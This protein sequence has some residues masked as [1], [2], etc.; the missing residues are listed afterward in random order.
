MRTDL[1]MLLAIVTILITINAFIFS[2]NEEFSSGSTTT[3]L[4]GEPT[5]GNVTTFWLGI[6]VW[7]FGAVPVWVDTL[8]LMTRAFGYIIFWKVFI[9]GVGT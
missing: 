3:N 6:F 7:T 2:I 4:V 9:R 8:L 1:L 5:F